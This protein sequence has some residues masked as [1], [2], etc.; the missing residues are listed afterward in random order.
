MSGHHSNNNEEEDF[1][2][3]ISDEDFDEFE[4]KLEESYQHKLTGGSRPESTSTANN[5]LQSAK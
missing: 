2:Q 4:K 3:N 1:V 5:R